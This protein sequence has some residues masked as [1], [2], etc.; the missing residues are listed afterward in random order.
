MMTQG[1]WQIFWQKT[2]NY[3]LKNDAQ[4]VQWTHAQSGHTHKERQTKMKNKA[5]CS[6]VIE[7]NKY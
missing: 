5:M 1:N 7:I 2:K 6:V 3:I 4:S